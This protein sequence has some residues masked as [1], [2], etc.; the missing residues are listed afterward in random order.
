M[1]K[2]IPASERLKRNLQSL[3]DQRMA[4]EAQLKF[5]AEEL[6]E[7]LK[8]SA[9]LKSAVR[10]FIKHPDIKSIA[11]TAGVGTA[12]AMVLKNVVARKLLGTITKLLI[13]VIY[14]ALRKT[15]KEL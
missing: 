10:N 7:S 8:P 14:S 1:E 3:Q 12:G 6:M 4:A 13:P 2:N 5:D 9:M 11:I 15:K